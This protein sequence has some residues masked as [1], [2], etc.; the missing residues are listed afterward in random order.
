M[1]SSDPNFL[2]AVIR[3]G[4]IGLFGQFEDEVEEVPPLTDK[5]A[6]TQEAVDGCNRARI[7]GGS[8]TNDGHWSEGATEQ[9]I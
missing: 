1:F 8:W 3:T 9:L 5:E 2:I 4:L 6:V 7:P